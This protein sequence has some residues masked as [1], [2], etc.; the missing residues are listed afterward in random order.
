MK[1]DI[2]KKLKAKKTIGQNSVKLYFV[3]RFHLFN[4]INHSLESIGDWGDQVPNHQLVLINLPPR[5]IDHSLQLSFVCRGCLH[6]FLLQDR[7]VLLNWP[8]VSHLGLLCWRFFF[9]K[10]FDS[11][12]YGSS[13]DI[14]WTLS[15]L[16]TVESLT[17][18]TTSPS[19]TS[20]S[21]SP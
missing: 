11:E 6:H 15:I 12:N 14:K 13:P 21:H 16:S 4:F 9:W 10:S 3:T 2:M 17:T 1:G 8:H 7:P 18:T 19:F 20:A 5:S